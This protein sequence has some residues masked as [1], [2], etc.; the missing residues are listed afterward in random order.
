MRV[1]LGAWLP[2]MAIVGLVVLGYLLLNWPGMAVTH[3]LSFLVAIALV[4]HLHEEER[5][6]GGFGYMFN[7]IRGNSD[8]PDRYPMSPLIAMIVDVSVFF[9]LFVPALLFPEVIWLGMAPMFLAGLELV[10][11]GSIGIVQ[12]RRG[13]SVYSPG[14][15]TAV[16]FASIAVMYVFVV[17][18]GGLMSGIAWL[19]AVLYFAGAITACLL[20]PERVLK[21][22]TTRWGFD[23]DHFLGFYRRYTTIEEALDGRAQ[24]SSAPPTA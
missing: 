17:G 10:S 21:S 23:H 4:L 14:L 5:Y 22:K 7:V 15:V 9:V 11:H 1:L 12:R 20:L 3:R 6:P 19:W 2:F 18:S 13:L 8:V 24:T 16:L